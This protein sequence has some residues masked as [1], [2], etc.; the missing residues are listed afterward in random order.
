[1]FWK[2]R[3]VEVNVKGALVLILATGVFSLIALSIAELYGLPSSSL[4]VGVI[5]YG[6]LFLATLLTLEQ[7]D[8]MPLHWVGLGVHPWIARE[9]GW[10]VALGVGMVVLAW[11]P[12]GLLGTVEFRGIQEPSKFF[13]WFTFLLLSAAGEELLFRGYLFQR[14]IELFG[15][16]LATLLFSAGFSLAHLGNPELSWLSL[17]NIFLAGIFFSACYLVTES[18][19]LPITAH[20]AWNTTLS[21]VL[22]APTSGILFEESFFRTTVENATLLTGGAFGPEGGIGTTV[23]LLFGGLILYLVPSLRIAP[24]TH[25]RSF[26]AVYKGQQ[27]QLQPNSEKDTFCKRLT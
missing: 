3:K 18:L 13:Y 11:L 20:I 27:E 6:A 12:S 16:L 7:I 17:A 2:R 19:W 23:V 22:G 8:Q 10:G 9:I 21:L 25:A 14:G 1:M 5:L 15:V 4:W 24:W 26:W